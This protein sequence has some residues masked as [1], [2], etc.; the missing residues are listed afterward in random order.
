MISDETNYSLT[1]HATVAVLRPLLT[2]LHRDSYLYWPFLVSTLLIGMLAWRCTRARGDLDPGK[3]IWKTFFSRYLGRGLWWHPSA[4]LDY[5][6]Y[7]INAILFPLLIGPLL[8][9]SDTLARALDAWLGIPP[10]LSSPPPGFWMM[11]LYTLLFFIAYDFGR[12]VAHSLLHDVPWLWE[13]HRVHHSAEVL[14]PMT[15]FRVHPVDAA[16]MALVPALTT[17]LLTWLFHHTLAPGITFITFLGIHII[18]WV[19]NLVGN[20]R[21]WHVWLSYGPTLNRW[22]IRPAHYQLH[23]SCE[24]RHM[25]CNR[26]FELA[27]W[28]RLYVPPAAPEQFRMGLNDGSDGRWR[29]VWQLYWWP[30]RGLWA[31]LRPGQTGKPASRPATSKA[32]VAIRRKAGHTHRTSPPCFSPAA[33]PKAPSTSCTADRSMTA[34]P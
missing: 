31:K 29:T 3:P 15:S 9:S 18:I 28:D 6:F 23:H 17:G 30:L 7:F 11:A 26:G 12:F 33:H 10:T 19:S 25:G 4:R 32:G 16:L 8:F 5:R 14:T 34:S 2:F 21:H 27:V 20:L 1:F 13:F 22:L 24:E